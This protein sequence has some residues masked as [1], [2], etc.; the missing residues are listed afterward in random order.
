MSQ[1]PKAR[2]GGRRRTAAHRHRLQQPGRR[3]ERPRRIAAAAPQAARPS[4]SPM[5][6][7]EAPGS[8]FWDR[9]RAGAEQ[10]AKQHGI[11]LQ[12][13]NDPDSG[14]QAT[15]VQNA[16]DS[17]V[18][19]IAVTLANPDAVGP[20]LAEGRTGGH[21]DRGVQLRHRQVPEVRREDVLRL[22]TRA[23]PGRAPGPARQGRRGG[24]AICVVPRAGQQLSGDPLRRGE[25]VLRE[26]REP[27][28]QRPG[29]AFGAVDDPGQARPGPLDHRHRHP[30]RRHRHRR[31]PGEDRPPAA[32]PRSSPSTSARTSSR[33]S[34]TS[35]SSSPSTSSP[36]CRATWPSTRCGCS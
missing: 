27:P 34:R 12:Y 23:S 36:T 4:P 22:A 30:R 11:D 7:H 18:D 20:A 31:R 2:H 14:K 17:K 35:R 10:A 5:I 32:R 24:K 26:H 13:S 6:T 8:T 33:P 25:E 29:P 3:P 9:I 1:H 19:G 21:P 16:I 28:G 15:L